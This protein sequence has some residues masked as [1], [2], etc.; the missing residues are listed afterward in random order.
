VLD[1]NKTLANDSDYSRKGIKN[2]MWHYACIPNVVQ[3]Q[4]LRTYGPEHWPMKAGNEELL[5]RLLNSP[6]WK[7]LKTTSGFHI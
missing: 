1:G 4:W 2:E 7:Y 3:E 6:E 5:M